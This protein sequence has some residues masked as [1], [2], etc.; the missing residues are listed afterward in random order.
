MAKKKHTE[1][2]EEEFL[3]DDYEESEELESESEDTVEP[4]VEEK[5]SDVVVPN[6][7]FGSTKSDPTRLTSSTPE[8]QKPGVVVEHKAKFA[9]GIIVRRRISD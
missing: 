4:I 9:E 3:G 2:V 7:V 5:S 8:S 1:E 6:K